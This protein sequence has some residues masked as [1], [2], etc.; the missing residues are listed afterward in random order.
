MNVI[1]LGRAV[2]FSFDI[3]MRYFC[4]LLRWNCPP[5]LVGRANTDCTVRKVLHWANAIIVMKL[6]YCMVG[7]SRSSTCNIDHINIPH[8]PATYI[9]KF[10]LGPTWNV[11][12]SMSELSTTP[13]LNAIMLHSLWLNFCAPSNNIS[14][15]HRK[16][17]F[18]GRG[19]DSKG[20]ITGS[21]GSSI[22][23]LHYVFSSWRWPC[24]AETYRCRM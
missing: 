13:T 8:C 7:G 23:L 9:R 1:S 3:R 4:D 16:P 18:L 11:H 5:F 22:M 15:R 24:S 17:L 12:T 20:S 2:C 6:P 14:S 21:T 10:S 19:N